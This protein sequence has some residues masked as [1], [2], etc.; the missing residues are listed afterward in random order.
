MVYSACAVVNQPG[1]R[2]DLVLPQSANLIYSSSPHPSHTLHHLLLIQP[3]IFYPPYPIPPILLPHPIPLTFH[4]TPLILPHTLYPPHPILSLSTL[5]SHSIPHTLSPSPFTLP[6]S[7]YLIPST[8]HTLSPH[9]PPYPS[10]STSYNLPPTPYPP[11]L[12][13]Y[14][15]HST[16]Y[17]YPPHP[18]THPTP[19]LLLYLHTLHPHLT[20]SNATYSLPHHPTQNADLQGV[21]CLQTSQVWERRLHS[22]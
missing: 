3:H 6:L 11:H 9:F 16:S 13:P 18:I 12:P 10:H 20:P 2:A 17:P 22:E 14:P 21:P 8:P 19:T 7:F 1:E 15:S 5:P 4:P